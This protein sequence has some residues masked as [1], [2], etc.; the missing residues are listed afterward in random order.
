MP[1]KEEKNSERDGFFNF[2][3]KRDVERSETGEFNFGAGVTWWTTW[4]CSFGRRRVIWE[5]RASRTMW[6]GWKKRSEVRS[7]TR[8][9]K[10]IC[11]RAN[12][13][14]YLILSFILSQC[15]DS[16]LEVMWWNLGVLVTAR[17][18]E[19]RTSWGRFVCVAGRL[20]RRDLQLSILEWMRNSNSAGSSLIY[21]LRIGLRSWILWRQDSETAKIYCANDK[22]LTKITTRLQAESTGESM[23]FLGK[24]KVGLLSLESC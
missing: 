2:L 1:N 20:S 11:E 19:L 21:S 6:R 15:R 24:L 7:L 9:E 14:A 16:I 17:A 8:F 13:V 22:F 23:I 18:A 10:F 12:L 3:R 5:R 4:R